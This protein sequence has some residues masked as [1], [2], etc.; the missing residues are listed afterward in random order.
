MVSVMWVVVVKNK[1]RKTQKRWFLRGSKVDRPLRHLNSSLTLTRELHK[2][3][4]S[5]VYFMPEMD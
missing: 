3:F 4:D 5:E 2:I 1:K